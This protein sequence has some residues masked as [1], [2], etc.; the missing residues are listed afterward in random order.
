M[1]YMTERPWRSSSTNR[2][3]RKHARWFDT[4][5]GGAPNAAASSETV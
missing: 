3:H 1:R 2:H 4:R 5:A